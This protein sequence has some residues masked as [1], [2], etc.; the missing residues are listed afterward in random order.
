M[1]LLSAVPCVQ[2]DDLSWDELRNTGVGWWLRSSDTL[3]RVIEKVRIHCVCHWL[4]KLTTKCWDRMLL[5][6]CML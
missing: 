2:Y 1:E 3:R 6:V 5:D 4:H